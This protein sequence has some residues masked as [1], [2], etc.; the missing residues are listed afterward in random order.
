MAL[1][2]GLVSAAALWA[3]TAEQKLEAARQALA[4]QAL[5]QSTRVEA[6]SWIDPQGRLQE[7]H[8]YRQASQVPALLTASGAPAQAIDLLRQSAS[9]SGHCQRVGVSHAP[10]ALQIQWPNRLP[11]RTRE[12]LNELITQTW[13]GSDAPRSWRMYAGAQAL[14][15]VQPD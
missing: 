14:P 7:F 1:T 3:Q 13:L 8:A 9:P 5:R 2:C 10:V 15:S 11:Q 12:R 6:V 4:E